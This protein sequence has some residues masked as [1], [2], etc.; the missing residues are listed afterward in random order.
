MF[1]SSIKKLGFYRSAGLMFE[2]CMYWFDEINDGATGEVMPQRFSR[3]AD[4]T[5]K[6][7]CLRYLEAKIILLWTHIIWYKVKVRWKIRPGG[8]GRTLSL[9]WGSDPKV[10]FP[11]APLSRM[12]IVHMNFGSQLVDKKPWAKLRAKPRAKILGK[13]VWPGVLYTYLRRRLVFISRV[14]FAASPYSN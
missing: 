9:L 6:K 10:T 12:K 11:A 2:E 1:L 8:L 3:R 4:T 5:K 14:N 7:V 13:K